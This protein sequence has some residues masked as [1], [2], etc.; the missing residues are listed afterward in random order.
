MVTSISEQ[1]QGITFYKVQVYTLPLIAFQIAAT[2]KNPPPP[3]QTM[4]IIIIL[5]IIVKFLQLIS[6]LWQCP[7]SLKSVHPNGN[8]SEFLR[9]ISTVRLTKSHHNLV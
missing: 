2:V 8:T 6:V 7:A 4:I 1:I 9:K 3:E 5:I